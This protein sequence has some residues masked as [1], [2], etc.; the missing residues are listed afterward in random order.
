MIIKNF[1]FYRLPSDLFGGVHGWSGLADRLAEALPARAF[2]ACGPG[3]AKASGWAPVAGESFVHAANGFLVFA[4]QEEG[5]IVPP[6]AL[7]EIVEARVRELEEREGRFAKKD[8]REDIRDEVRSE[9]LSRAFST[10]KIT[11]AIIDTVTGLMW[12]GTAS[13]GPAE[14]VLSL[15]RETLG[16]WPARPLRPAVPAEDVLTGWVSNEPPPLVV[17]NGACDL[18]GEEGRSVKVRRFPVDEAGLKDYI[19]NGMRVARLAFEFNGLVSATLDSD[20]SL[21]A[22]KFVGIEKAVPEDDTPEALAAAFDSDFVLL[23]GEMAAM[24]KTMAG[25]F[26]GWKEA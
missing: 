3:Q 6:A 4:R 23:T 9:A 1:R 19:D 8:E 22:V 11:P 7:K 12:V 2:A 26:G 16:S 5:K 21:R 10:H 18:A 25:W 14:D 17:L 13:A 15:L 20:L 24:L